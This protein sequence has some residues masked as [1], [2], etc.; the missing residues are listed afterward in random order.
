MPYRSSR[1]REVNYI[2]APNFW[3]DLTRA[4]GPLMEQSMFEAV[5]HL[6]RL[7]ERA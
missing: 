2:E 3:R 6:H 7:F 5:I 1:D 4:V